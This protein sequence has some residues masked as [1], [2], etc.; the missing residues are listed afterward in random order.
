M[1]NITLRKIVRKKKAEDKK[2]KNLEDSNNPI[3]YFGIGDYERIDNYLRG[4]TK[5]I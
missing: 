1:R 5:E 3:L 2:R 4:L